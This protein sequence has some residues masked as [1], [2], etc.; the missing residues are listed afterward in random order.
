LHWKSSKFDLKSSVFNGFDGWKS[1]LQREILGVGQGWTGFDGVMERVSDGIQLMKCAVV[2]V[3]MLFVC[4]VFVSLMRWM[5]Q[6]D[7]WK[8]WG[9]TGAE[10]G[11]DGLAGA[12]GGSVWRWVGGIAM[13]WCGCG[14]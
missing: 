6:F 3:V 5:M 14:F 1:V 12:G 2:N 4:N 7:G 11:V 13:R 8:A 9:W 10:V